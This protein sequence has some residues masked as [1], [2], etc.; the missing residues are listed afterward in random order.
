MQIVELF[1]GVDPAEINEVLLSMIESLS[2][3]LTNFQDYENSTGY[4]SSVTLL[5][6][7]ARLLDPALRWIASANKSSAKLLAK[8]DLLYN[9]AIL[10]INSGV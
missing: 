5:Q 10:K 8:Y 4:S 7:R 6:N 9:Q 2:Y 3:T 1:E